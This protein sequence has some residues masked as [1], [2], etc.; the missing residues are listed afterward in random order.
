MKS[1]VIIGASGFGREV[2]TWAMDDPRHDV[3]FRVKGFLDT[4]RDLLDRFAKDPHDLPRSVPH[5]EGLKTQYRRDLK[6][7]G[8]PLTY[9]PVS[10]D[11]FLCAVGD[12]A[13]RREY[14]APIID[15]GGE[16]AVLF[17]P[18]ASVS[19]FLSIGRGSI[20]GRFV[21]ISPDVT[22]GEFVTVNSY[23]A[24]GH[25]V[26]VGDWCE[27][28]GHCLIAGRVKIGQRVRVHGGATITPDVTIGDDA[29]VG[30]GSVVITHVPA[31]VTV[32]GN[33]AKKFVWK[34]SGEAYRSR[35]D[36]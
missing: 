25:D 34:G 35:V 31:G 7:I 17:H 4:R 26:S 22:I 12:P 6:I 24:L 21:S 20:I 10:D 11:I 30:A 14:A 16:F 1:L 29:I 5:A 27:I 36:A 2:L 28:D 32:F 8:D 9:Q 3:E 15:R 13:A 33:P 19:A 18:R 23:T